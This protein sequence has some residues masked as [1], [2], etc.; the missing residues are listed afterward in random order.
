MPEHLADALA[1]LPKLGMVGVNVTVPHKEA[2]LAAVT[3]ASDLARRIGAVNTIFMESDGAL[4]GD[5]T[6]GAGFMD[7]LR[8]GGCDWSVT[9]G[10]AVVVG[11]GGAARA[12]CAALIDRGISQLRLINRSRSRA[13]MLISDIGGRI[14]AVSWEDRSTALEGAALLVNTTSLGMVGSPPLEL[15]LGLLPRH[16]VVT[17]IVYNPLKTKL[18]E[19]AEARGNPIVDGL[20][21]LLHQARPGFARWFGVEPDVTDEL[22]AFVAEG[23]PR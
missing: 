3:E 11:A 12:V 21:M 13:E 4:F 16:A 9:H 14:D 6:D 7:N 5:N 2:A 10:P 23:L 20:G 8:G 18:L 15:D 19:A 17:D 1:A 22:R